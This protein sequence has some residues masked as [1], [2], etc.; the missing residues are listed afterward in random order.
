MHFV[1]G[2]TLCGL[3]LSATAILAVPPKV[4]PVPKP[5]PEV[6]NTFD[7]ATV[8]K[9]FQLE[10]EPASK[11]RLETTDGAELR[12]FDAGKTGIF[13]ANVAGT[14]SVIVIG[15]GGDTTEFR[16]TVT[17]DGSGPKPPQ[18]PT[19][20]VVDPLRE[21][22]KKAF[23]AEPGD[24][25]TKKEFAKDLAELYRQASILAL[26]PDI[27]T[28]GELMKRAQDAAN[29][30]IGSDK[31]V[32]LRKVVAAQLSLILP[33]DATLTDNQRK[34]VADLFDKLVPILNSFG[35]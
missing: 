32:P 27:K 35:N 4:T 26:K 24:A 7:G 21:S 34:K 9:M 20:P 22:L 29:I 10:A 31:M 5:K 33:T 13:V 18:P 6:I 28:S 30:L 14:Y 8:N 16:I 12:V 19:P 23:D 15:P 17:D 11:W 3:L 25:A 2:W 1:W